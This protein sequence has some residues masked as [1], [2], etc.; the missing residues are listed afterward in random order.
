MLPVV[1][2]ETGTSMVTTSPLMM[3]LLLG[4]SVTP[5]GTVTATTRVPS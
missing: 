1:T 5:V 4:T 2:P 3:S